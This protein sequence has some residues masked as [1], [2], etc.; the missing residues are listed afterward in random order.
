MEKNE[1]ILKTDYLE[2]R[3]FWESYPDIEI[4]LYEFLKGE[5]ENP[6]ILLENEIF[7]NHCLHDY[8]L[9]LSGLNIKSSLLKLS[10]KNEKYFHSIIFNNSFIISSEIQS[11]SIFKI[12]FNYSTFE[13]VV[14][15]GK[16]DYYFYNCMIDKIEFNEI[17]IVSIS[18]ENSYLISV[19]VN[20]N[21][22]FEITE[23][24]DCTIVSINIHDDSKLGNTV[25]KNSTFVNPIQERNIKDHVWL[26]AA[27]EEMHK[28]LHGK[29]KSWLWGFTSNY[30][31][32]FWRWLVVS[33][34]F[35]G[36]FGLVYQFMEFD[37]KPEL[38]NSVGKFWSKIYFS[39]VTFTTLGY[40]DVTPV[41][42]VAVFSVMTEVV[43]GYIMLGALISILADKFARRS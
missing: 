31:R 23:F 21:S 43:I 4:L 41:S 27:K 16:D 6:E 7:K 39:I 40:G 26:E 28:T 13:D 9:E 14:I 12:K 11:D 1:L 38:L 37:I 19:D 33:S 35:A 25:F 2:Q 8:E 5:L 30:G 20:K 17:E 10:Y 18:F 24:K 36:V 15:N 29:I 34:I 42:K 22:K 3:K 32:S